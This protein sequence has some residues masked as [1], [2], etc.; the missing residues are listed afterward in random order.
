MSIAQLVLE[1]SNSG[2]DNVIQ[3]FQCEDGSLYAPIPVTMTYILHLGV[4]QFGK[5]P[6]GEKFGLL[7]PKK[8]DNHMGDLNH[9]FKGSYLYLR[10]FGP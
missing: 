5:G 8:D 1:D 10:S 2:R 9:M 4:E 3:H 6:V 7:I